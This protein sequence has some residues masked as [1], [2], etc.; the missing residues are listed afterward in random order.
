MKCEEKEA[1][2]CVSVTVEGAAHLKGIKMIDLPMKTSDC[3][4]NRFFTRLPT[5]LH[6]GDN[7]SFIKMSSDEWMN[8]H[9][10]LPNS[11]DV[12]KDT[13]EFSNLISL[14]MRGLIWWS[15]FKVGGRL[16]PSV[17]KNAP[18]KIY[19]STS[20]SSAFQVLWMLIDIRQ[21]PATCRPRKWFY[22]S[23]CL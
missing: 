2:N 19:R 22:C 23:R 3:S 8:E 12:F 5:F 15:V 4:A 11:E 14:T 17:I 21:V 1:A 16:N 9:H 13:N 7:I 6:F 10:M 20:S 18:L